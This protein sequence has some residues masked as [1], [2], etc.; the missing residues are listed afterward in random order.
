MFVRVV[1]DVEKHDVG[2][3]VVAVVIGA[4]GEIIVEADGALAA[5]GALGK[6]EVIPLVLEALAVPV[7]WDFSAELF[8]HGGGE[9]DVVVEG[10]IEGA[11]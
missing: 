2:K 4:D 3:A 11:L 8:D 7:G 10:A 5:P 9:I 6:D 1:L